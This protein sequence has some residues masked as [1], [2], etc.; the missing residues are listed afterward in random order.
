MSRK[1]A[2]YL[3]QKIMKTNNNQLRL[4]KRSYTIDKNYFMMK[5]NNDI[6]FATLTAKTLFR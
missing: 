5:M 1:R 6:Q 2:S 4:L 3:L